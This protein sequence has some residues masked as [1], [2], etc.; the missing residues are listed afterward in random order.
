[1]ALDRRAGV[2]MSRFRLRAQSVK[3]ATA[4][5]YCRRTAGNA[6]DRRKKPEVREE[7]SG[8]LAGPGLEAARAR[9]ALRRR[10][11]ASRW[12]GS[13][14][15][16]VEAKPVPLDVGA[17][18]SKDVVTCSF[19]LLRPLAKAPAELDH[20][21]IN[22]GRRAAKSLWGS[23]CLKQRSPLFTQLRWVCSGC[24]CSRLPSGGSICQDNFV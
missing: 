5:A 7:V 8:T 13:R 15:G 3:A 17:G 6:V 14:R 1:M 19:T 23:S 20:P 21:V 12:R 2:E 16:T 10:R 9:A 22:K 24:Y 18:F 11:A 4:F